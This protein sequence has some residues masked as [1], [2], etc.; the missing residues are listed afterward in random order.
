[1]QRTVEHL[2]DRRNGPKTTANARYVLVLAELTCVVGHVMNLAK[3]V[4]REFYEKNKHLFPYKDWIW[5]DDYVSQKL[6]DAESKEK[7]AEI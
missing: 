1:V 2:D 7:E 5:Y 3:I 6:I 4:I